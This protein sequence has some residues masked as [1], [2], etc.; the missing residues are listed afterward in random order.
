MNL[1]LSALI[2]HILSEITS[3]LASDEPAIVASIEQELS[4][5]ITKT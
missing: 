1:L 3:S 5:L 4:L 2:G